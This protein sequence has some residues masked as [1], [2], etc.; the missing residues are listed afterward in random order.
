MKR[1]FLLLSALC[2]TM[3]PA[4]ALGQSAAGDQASEFI[5]SEIRKPPTNRTT[6]PIHEDAR[7]AVERLCKSRELCKK[8]VPPLQLPS[9]TAWVQKATLLADE[10][11]YTATFDLSGATLSVH[12]TSVVAR[13]PETSILRQKG[14]VPERVVNVE[15]TESGYD[16]GFEEFGASYLVSLECFRAADTRCVGPEFLRAIAKSMV[17]YELP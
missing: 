16:A 4:L 6:G 7:A 2:T 1:P 3:V 5:R 14:R 9:E 11:A 15:R 13:V 10:T 12:G 8:L 17:V